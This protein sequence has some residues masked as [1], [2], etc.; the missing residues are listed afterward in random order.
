MGA[1]VLNPGVPQWSLA[2]APSGFGLVVYVSE[3]FLGS[4]SL[5]KFEVS[6]EAETRIIPSIVRYD[7]DVNGMLLAHW[8][9]NSYRRNDSTKM[10]CSETRR[11]AK[12]APFIRFPSRLRSESVERSRYIR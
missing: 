4:P 5:Q 11:A 3:P 1:L 10:E 9:V 12:P 7:C 8:T 6:H 2:L